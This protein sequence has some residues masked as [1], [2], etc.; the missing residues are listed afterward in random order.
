MALILEEKDGKEKFVFV[1]DNTPGL[2]GPPPVGGPPPADDPNKD[3]DKLINASIKM[4]LQDIISTCQ[5]IGSTDGKGG[6]QNAG[7]G[8]LG[9]SG[10]ASAD[11]PAEA[12]AKKALATAEAAEKAAEGKAT[13]AE[14]AAAAA[15]AKAAASGPDAQAAKAADAAYKTAQANEA[16][17]QG[18]LQAAEGTLASDEAALKKLTPG[19]QAYNAMLQQIVGDGAAVLIIQNLVSDYQ[20]TFDAAQKAVTAA[21]AAVQA[22][23]GAATKADAAAKLAEQDLGKAQ[24]AV[25]AAEA[26]LNKAE[27]ADPNSDVSKM[28]HLIWDH[29]VFWALLQVS[30]AGNS[31]VFAILTKA[32]GEIADQLEGNQYV[33]GI[34][35]QINNDL[36]QLVSL[37]SGDP[38]KMTPVQKTQMTKLIQDLQKQL[39]L[40]KDVINPPSGNTKE[41]QEAREAHNSLGSTL[42]GQLSTLVDDYTTEG[43]Q[44]MGEQG[45]DPDAFAKMIAAMQKGDFSGFKTFWSKMVGETG[46]GSPGTGPTGIYSQTS[47]YETGLNTEGS[48]FMAEQ[49]LNTKQIDM[50]EKLWTSGFTTDKGILQS[51]IGN[52]SN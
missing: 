26:A 18:L 17:L 44:D 22:D 43:S 7:G 47:T 40:L 13:A 51:V 29:N 3:R 24:K 2:G 5:E 49:N 31:S 12:A 30:M 50:I 10:P 34:I 4:E 42:V 46:K 27:M 45:N 14:R 52:I 36:Q 19:S 28:H 48:K 9:D 23:K 37:T 6:S 38:A 16:K 15:D 39:S 25:A 8:G 1:P 11:T 32:L 21:D 41:D 35:S 33:T 20:P